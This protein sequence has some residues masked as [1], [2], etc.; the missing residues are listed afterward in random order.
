MHLIT[1]AGYKFIPVHEPSKLQSA[2]LETCAVLD[3][4]GTILISHEGIN[5]NLC[6]T[7]E[8]ILRFK[9]S[10]TT[11][12]SFSDI[13][14]RESPTTIKA[15]NK[16]KIKIK[17]EII[18][19]G[20]PD[21]QPDEKRAPAITPQRLKQWLDEKRDV[22]LLDARNEYEVTLGTF[23]G[24][25]TLPLSSFSQLPHLLEKLP[26]DKPLVTFCTSGIRC[27]KAAL[28]LLEA[29]FNEVYQ[30]EGGILNY[31]SVVGG[32]HYEGHCFVFDNRVALD[33]HLQQADLEAS[34]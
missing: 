27:E 11:E 25:E 29:G 5:I 3:L 31:F 16:L 28:Y 32:A 20:K 24:A 14:F 7:R 9:N 12:P 21:I 18:T 17:K 10:L 13:T 1:I 23:A 30:L 33:T 6:G 15:Y 34:Q 26:R 19:F 8:N 4:L 22:T 2:L